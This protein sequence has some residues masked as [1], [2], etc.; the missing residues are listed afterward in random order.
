MST[1]VKKSTSVVDRLRVLGPV[2]SLQDMVLH[3]D[4]TSDQA[5]V[6]MNRWAQ[7]P[8]IKKFGPGVAFNLLFH[9]DAEEKH[10]GFALNKVLR[11]PFMM[12]GGSSL[13]HSG[14]T[15]QVHH[16]MEIAVPVMRGKTSLPKLSCGITLVPRSV[17]HFNKLNAQI[18]PDASGGE[19][20]PV[21]SPAY[22]LADAYLADRAGKGSDL[23]TPAD[24]IDKDY[25]DD[26][27]VENFRAALIDL[28]ASEDMVDE[29]IEE[30]EG[31]LD[32]DSDD[33]PMGFF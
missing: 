4:I 28:G 6:Y 5:S 33:E 24:E 22:A 10:M 30:Y 26:S 13:Y 27:Q 14:W 9:P 1:Q 8:N 20:I 11:R 19:N 12:I 16:Q 21:V 7:T 31:S 18:N 25:L 23:L 32:P 29:A 3:F 17:R 15:T 2:F